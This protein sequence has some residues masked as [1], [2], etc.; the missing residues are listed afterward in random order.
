MLWMMER[1]QLGYYAEGDVIISP[2]QGPVDRFLIIKQGMVHGEQNVAH[3]SEADTWLELSAG[4]CFP[5]GR[6]AGQ[7]S[8]G[9]PV[10]GG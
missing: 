5:L 2:E 10:S 6:V 3:A 4:E 7:P 8:C 9:Q 1:M